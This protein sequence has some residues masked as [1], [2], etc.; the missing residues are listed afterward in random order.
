[1]LI[2][3][4]GSVKSP[5]R[6]L[7]VVF[8]TAMRDAICLVAIAI[9]GHNCSY[10]SEDDAELMT[11]FLKQTAGMQSKFESL[12]LNIRCSVVREM[13]GEGVSGPDQK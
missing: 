6:G 10:A 4:A 2:D 7:C 9:T 12:D 8:L 3:P 11:E 5:W 13:S 1:M